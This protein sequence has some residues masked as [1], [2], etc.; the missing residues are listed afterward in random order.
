M[1]RMAPNKKLIRFSGSRGSPHELVRRR[2]RRA[3]QHA[4]HA[5][6][7]LARLEGLGDVVVGAGLEPDDAIDRVGR[8]RHHDDADA[9]RTLAQPAR[10]HEAVLARQPDIEQHQCGKLALQQFA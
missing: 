4:L 1:L 9:A 5:R 2:A 7:Q 10:Q 3:P 6:K 8:R